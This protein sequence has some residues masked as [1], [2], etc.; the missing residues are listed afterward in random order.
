MF[1]VNMLTRNILFGNWIFTFDNILLNLFTLSTMILRGQ[2]DN[3]LAT[4][5]EKVPLSTCKMCE[6]TSSC[7]C[8]LSHLGLCSPLINSIGHNDSGC[9]QKVL[10]R[11]C[12]L[13]LAFAVCACLKAT[14]LFGM[15]HMSPSKKKML[16]YAESILVTYVKG[17][18]N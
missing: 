6:F 13:I 3:I 5:K 17:I 14:F 12:N 8:T 11:L 4:S 7:T 10:I 16:K 15:I 18:S 2:T 9:R 1:R